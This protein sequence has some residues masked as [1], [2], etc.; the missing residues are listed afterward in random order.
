MTKARTWIRMPEVRGF[1]ERERAYL[2][3]AMEVVCGGQGA[4]DSACSNAV[5]YRCRFEYHAHNRPPVH[6]RRSLCASCAR[7]WVVWVDTATGRNVPDIDRKI[8]TLPELE[9]ED[10]QTRLWP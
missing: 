4:R 3:E 5:A 2:T 9:Y 10:R 8:E 6:V 7:A 1:T